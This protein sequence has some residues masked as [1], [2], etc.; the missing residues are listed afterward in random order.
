LFEGLEDPLQD[1]KDEADE[2]FFD[3][4]PTTTTKLAE[5]EAQF[6]L[7]DTGLTDGERR[8]RL[9][10]A[11]VP[12][13]TQSPYALQM[14]LQ[15][16]GFNVYIHE[17]WEPGTEAAIGV[18]GE[19]TTRNP[20]A[21]VDAEYR[22]EPWYMQSGDALA[23]SGEPD[24]MTGIQLESGG[25]YPLSRKLTYSSPV[26][27]AQS[28]ADGVQSGESV[29]MTGNYGTYEEVTEIPLIPTDPDTWVHVFYVCDETFGDAATI[30]TSRKDEF[31]TLIL[32]HKPAQTWAVIIPNWS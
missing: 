11:W 9:A 26:Y 2:T 25:G 4:F 22:A 18:H 13:D 12:S 5:W 27:T 20:R 7:R 21:I 16:A 14:I 15:G 28:G 6:G 24:A 8:T 32:K 1:V 10:G 29:A 3:M 23:Q 30:P 31:E 19:P 17:W